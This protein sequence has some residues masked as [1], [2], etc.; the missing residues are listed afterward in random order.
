MD[1]NWEGLKKYLD[2]KEVVVV[3]RHKGLVQLLKDNGINYPVIEHVQAEHVRDKV[4]IGILPL[5]LAAEAAQ[6][7]EISM[8]I[9]LEKRGME[10]SSKEMETYLKDINI[11]KV[12]KI[13]WD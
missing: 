6:V 11:F 12:K 10:I 2:Q 13:D 3:T 5:H 7:I 8:D 9:P 4:V 1:M